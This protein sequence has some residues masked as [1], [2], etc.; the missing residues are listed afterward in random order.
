MVQAA[1]ASFAWRLDDGYADNQT[2][3]FAVILLALSVGNV[4]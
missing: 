1:E 3:D 4:N 2:A